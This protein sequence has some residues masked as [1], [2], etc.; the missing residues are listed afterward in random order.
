VLDR[1]E[2]PADMILLT[3][4]EHSGSCYIETS[5]IDG[6]TNLKV[7]PGDLTVHTCPSGVWAVIVS[8]TSFTSRSREP[9]IRMVC[10]IKHAAPTAEDGHG[11]MWGSEPEQLFG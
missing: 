5:N 10:Q 4:S 7:R 9:C 8:S 2:I 11:P 3:S 1:H 6:E